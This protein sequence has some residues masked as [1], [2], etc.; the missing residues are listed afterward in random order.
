MFYRDMGDPVSQIKQTGGIQAAGRAHV[1]RALPAKE[2]AQVRT[3]QAATDSFL[4]TANVKNLLQGKPAFS[5]ITANSTEKGIEFQGS[6]QFGKEEMQKFAN[7][8]GS[9]FKGQDVTF[10]KSQEGDLVASVKDRA[11][12]QDSSFATM[13]PGQSSQASGQAPRGRGRPPGPKK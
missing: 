2:A 8:V 4:K 13:M 1:A 3:A 7:F 10:S 12:R 9:K 6:K 5:Q 11:P